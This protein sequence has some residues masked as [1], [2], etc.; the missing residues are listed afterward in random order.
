MG[1]KIKIISAAALAAAAIPL[2][3]C[4]SS[5]SA[6][7]APALPA[8]EQAAIAAMARHCTQDAAQLASMVAETH[9][10]EVKNG[11]TGESVTALAGHLATVVAAYGSKKVSC[12]DPF[13]AYLT[14]REGDG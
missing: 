5:P 14:E 1:I 4:G 11:V 13:A 2:A 8:A 10:L 9:T 7:T 3:A 6:P 12:A